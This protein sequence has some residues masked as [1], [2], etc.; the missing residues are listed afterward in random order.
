MN[1]IEIHFYVAETI[2]KELIYASRNL[3]EA[4]SDIEKDFYHDLCLFL[5]MKLNKLHVEMNKEF[6]ISCCSRC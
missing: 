3:V 6:G 5:S 2:R 4:S 1:K